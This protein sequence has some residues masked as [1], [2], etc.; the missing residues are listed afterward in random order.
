MIYANDNWTLEKSN[1]YH[2]EK[3]AG[4]IETVEEDWL[5]QCSEGHYQ[6]EE[7]TLTLSTGHFGSH[8]NLELVDSHSTSHFARH[9]D[10]E[11]VECRWEVVAHTE[12]LHE[13]L[14]RYQLDCNNWKKILHMNW[15]NHIMI[16]GYV[17]GDMCYRQ[18][19]AKLAMYRTAL[20][21][22]RILLRQGL[23]TRFYSEFVVQ[24]L[25]WSIFAVNHFLIINH[26]VILT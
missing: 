25:Q 22:M 14:G 1:S 21:H 2:S 13:F 3:Q 5:Q 6:T 9:H 24:F 18:N 4:L 19:H 12:E 23:N 10:L 20:N 7:K 15:C 17:R 26:M 8:H 11:P 16:G